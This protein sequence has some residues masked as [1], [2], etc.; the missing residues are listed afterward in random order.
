[1]TTGAARTA[2]EADV[3]AE[4]AAADLDA[5]RDD[6]DAATRRLV[7]L[8]GM[9]CQKLLKISLNTFLPTLVSCVKCR[10]RDVLSI[11][12]RAVLAASEASLKQQLEAATRRAEDLAKTRNEL[13]A[14]R[15]EVGPGRYCPPRHRHAFCTLVS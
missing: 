11:L 12:W 2:A 7:T 9:A 6:L 14:S 3:A 8:Q 10:P 5:V 4:A 15:R 13:E 1:M